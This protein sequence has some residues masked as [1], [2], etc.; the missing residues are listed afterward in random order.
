M[1]NRIVLLALMFVAVA[2]APPAEPVGP[3]LPDPRY[4]APQPPA[5]RD[6][7]PLASDPC[8]TILS[9][10]QWRYLGFVP[11]GEPITLPTGERSCEW[12]GP[13]RLPYVN[14]GIAG[15][16]DILVDTYR[17]RH[18]S[19]FQAIEV[20]GL[21]AAVEQ[22]STDSLSCNITVGTADGQGFLAIYDAALGENG[23]RVDP[24]GEA[25]RIAEQIVADLSPLAK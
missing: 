18:F 14:I 16:R 2:C 21:P 3:P 6:V 12:R 24:C 25:R 15:N 11:T 8:G 13:S 17:V 22:T 5:P 20:E 23:E 10:D 1:R 19:R 4:G 9:P 7:R